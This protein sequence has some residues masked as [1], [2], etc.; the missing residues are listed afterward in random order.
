MSLQQKA[1][2]IFWEQFLLH[3]TIT[4]I[5]EQYRWNQAEH[6]RYI[7][8]QRYDGGKMVSNHFKPLLDEFFGRQND[9]IPKEIAQQF[10]E[11][12]QTF[13]RQGY[14][15]CEWL[16]N[17]NA[18]VQQMRLRCL[19]LQPRFLADECV[20]PFM[21]A[22]KDMKYCDPWNF[23]MWSDFDWNGNTG[24]HIQK[25]FS[26]EQVQGFHRL[27][28]CEELWTGKST[29]MHRVFFAS[30]AQ[31]LRLLSRERNLLLGTLRPRIDLLA[32]NAK[33]DKHH[34]PWCKAS[35]Y[36]EEISTLRELGETDEEARA[37][38]E[39]IEQ[40]G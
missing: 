30:V 18:C 11:L 15:H 1:D 36:K 19:L 14:D 37:A 33:Y 23:E 10:V 9:A 38:V 28:L 22:M 7:S 6:P 3:P 26:V 2:E 4:E 29:E 5:N 31:A 13:A 35:F 12:A 25:G 17:A 16:T 32:R 39:I 40:S 8:D 24:Y 20:V 27:I 34:E 21:L